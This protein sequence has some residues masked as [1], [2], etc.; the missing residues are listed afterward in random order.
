MENSDALLQ[1]IESYFSDNM[2]E[3]ERK[4]FE[5]EI[6]RDTELAAEVA[7]FRQSHEAIQV[8]AETKLK[9]RLKKRYYE[10]TP[11]KPVRRL[12]RQPWAM[13]AAASVCLLIAAS[14]WIFFPK[15]SSP[16]SPEELFQTYYKPNS[17][18]AHRGDDN[19]VIEAVNEAYLNEDYEKVI[20]LI[21]KLSPDSI[22]DRAPYIFMLLGSSYLAHREPEE[23]ISAFDKVQE[24][25]AYQWK[26]KWYKALAVLQLGNAVEAQ[27]LLK[28]LTQSREFGEDAKIILSRIEE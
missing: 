9:N 23:A 3:K 21:G 2:S 26:A 17:A 1:K 22:G 12:F 19:P 20:Q 8:F 15:N 25:S 24:G 5:Q 18:I 27:P 14:I 6:S 16:L 28:D 10:E 11:A 13:V 7:L 4:S